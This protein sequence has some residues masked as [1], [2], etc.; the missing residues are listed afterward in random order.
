MRILVKSSSANFRSLCEDAS[1]DRLIKWRT[2][3]VINCHRWRS[4][5]STRFIGVVCANE[6]SGTTT[7]AYLEQEMLVSDFEQVRGIFRMLIGSRSLT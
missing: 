5:C 4:P 3:W 6:I 7:M 1:I 2:D